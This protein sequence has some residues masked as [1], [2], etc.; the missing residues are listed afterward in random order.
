MSLNANA[1]L[2]VDEFFNYLK[3]PT[4]ITG[5]P[6]YSLVEQLINRA[7]TWA[8][9]YTKGPIVQASI[10][11]SLDGN[12][13]RVLVD[14]L[15]LS[16]YPIVSLSSVVQDTIDITSKISSYPEGALY[17]T[18][19]GVF[20]PGRQNVTVTYVA[21]YGS[22]MSTIPLDI[23]QAALE[24]VHYWFKRDSLDYSQTFGESEVIVQQWRFPGSA[25]KMLDPYKRVKSAAFGGRTRV[26]VNWTGWDSNVVYPDWWW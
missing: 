10:T 20:N 18:G 5:D 12:P 2:T 22:S 1:L 4:S 3:Q 9:T 14:E 17:F 23:K 6:N 25:A 8:E 11:E 24:L 21:G 15:L 7:S 26:S 13:E 19:G 16:F